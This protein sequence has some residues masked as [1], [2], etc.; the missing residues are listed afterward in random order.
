VIGGGFPGDGYT[1]KKIENTSVKQRNKINFQ[2]HLVPL[3]VLV[4]LSSLARLSCGSRSSSFVFGR[5]ECGCGQGVGTRQ[6]VRLMGCPA[7]V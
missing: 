1:I 4:D 5:Q 2:A 7:R 3:D 6:R